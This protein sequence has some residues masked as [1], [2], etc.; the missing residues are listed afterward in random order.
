MNEFSRLLLREARKE[1]QLI[2]GR[3]NEFGANRSKSVVPE[4]SPKSC[5]EP[6]E[7]ALVV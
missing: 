1:Y 4:Y 6:S 7:L 5:Q 3:C 2:L